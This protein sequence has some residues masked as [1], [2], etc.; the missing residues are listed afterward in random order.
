MRRKVKPPDLDRYLVHS[1]KY[2]SYSDGAKLFGVPYYS[3]VSIVK[4]A[5]ANIRIRKKVIVDLEILN[6][7]IESKR[8]K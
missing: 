1:P 3:F 5:N 2:V 4:E 8:E 7:Y 6:D